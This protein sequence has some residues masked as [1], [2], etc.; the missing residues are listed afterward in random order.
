MSGNANIGGNATITGDLTVNGTTTTI[1]TATLDV[2]DKNITL[3]YGTGD[4]SASADGAGI[5]IQ[6]AVDAS[7]DAT[8]LWNATNDKFVF[9]HDISVTGAS[10]ADNA[11]AFFGTGND[12]SIFHDGSNSYVKD[13]GTGD[14]ML[15]GVNV[16]IQGATTGNNMFVG[17][18]N[19]ASTLYYQNNARLATT[20]AGIDVTGNIIADNNLTIQNSSAYGSIELGGVSG[21]FIDIKRPFSDDYDLRLIAEGD[22]GVINVASGELTIQRAGS[23]KLATSSAGVEVTGTFTASSTITNSSSTNAYL[24][25]QNGGSH[26]SGVIFKEEGSAN[27]WEAPYISNAND[28]LKFYSYTGSGVQMEIRDGVNGNGGTIVSGFKIT[29]GNAYYGHYGAVLL[30]SSQ[31][32]TSTSRGWMITNAYESNKFALLFS[33]SA[34]TLPALT[35]SGATASGTSV[36]LEINN[37]GNATFAGTL[38][39]AGGTTSADL[40]F[41]DNDKAVFGAGSDLQIYHTSSQS[42][43]EDAGTGNLNFKSNGNNFNFLDGS[44]NLVMQID[45]DSETTLYHNTN[46]KLATTSTGIA[47][48]GNATF[49][50]NGKAIFG[51]GSDLSIYHSGSHS[52][53]QDAGTGD[54]QLW[55]N[56]VRIKNAAGTENMAS[57]L[58]NGAAVFNYD[59]SQK[60]ATTSYGVSITG[61]AVASDTFEVGTGANGFLV[62]GGQTGTTTIGKLHN[63]SGVLT[64]DTDSTRSIKLATG[65]TERL[66]I[67]GTTG[68]AGLGTS[69]PAAKLDIVDTSA[70]VQMRVYKNDGTKN[71][72]LTLTA[73]DSGAKIHYRDADNAGALRFNNNLGEVMRIPANTTRL[74]IGTSSPRSTINASSASG[75]ILTLESSDTTLGENEVVGQIDFYANDASTNST[76]NKA[77]I[78][79]YSETAGGNKVALD[80]A[81]STSTSATGVVAMTINSDGDV[82]IGTSSVTSVLDVVGPAA[83]PASLA[84]VDTASTARFRADSTNNDSLYIAEASS[85]MLVQ[86]NDGATNSTTAKPLSLQPFGGNVG[87]GTSP[88]SAL[89]VSDAVTHAASTEVALIQNTTTGQ[90]VALALQAVADNGGTGNE[91]AIYFDAGADGTAANNQLQFTADHQSDTTPDMIITG[92]GNV[93]IGT[94]PAAALDIIGANGDQFRVSNTTSDAT[95]KN[96]YHSVRHYTNAEEDFI[97]SVAQSS[98]SQNTLYLGGSTSLGNAATAIRF[99]TAENTT[100]TSGSERMRIDSSGNLLVGKTTVGINLEGVQAAADGSIA[101]VRDGGTAGYFQ[102]KTSDGEIVN[103]RRDNSTVGSIGANGGDLF[104]GTGDTNIL[105]ADG[106]DTIM[107]ATTGGATRDAAID[108]G[109]SS[110]RFQNLYLSGDVYA[111]NIKGQND[112]NTKIEFLGSDVTRFVQGGSERARLDSGRNLLVGKTTTGVA[113]LGIEARGSGFLGVTRNAA[114]PAYFNRL[115]D[116]GDIAIFS[117]DSS[118]IC[119]IGSI[120]GSMYIQGKAATGKSGLTFYGS[121]IEPRDNGAGA[122]AAI[123]LGISSARF[124]DLYL[125]GTAYIN[126]HIQL[127]NGGELRAKDTGGTVRTIARVNTSNHLEYG[128]SGNGVI[129]FMGKGTYSEVARFDT[130]G[131]YLVGKTRCRHR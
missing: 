78:K 96:A 89:H 127:D 6:D 2:E 63:A 53:I 60:L 67:D 105:F 55:G 35:T 83:R 123:D 10:F 24:T 129:K 110:G 111:T 104:V 130:N 65:S 71:T 51:A 52:I 32:Y 119:T 34:T 31:N 59:N 99:Y 45:I 19:G 18:D 37:S 44:D 46:A 30:N 22:G 1:N 26:E 23:A 81:T 103:F 122:D 3:N 40:N 82:G 57:F 16:R 97:W 56:V 75:A 106:S 113:N 95:L 33:G 42:Y 109:T 118:E 15:Q 76:G 80:F 121:Y 92:A 12:L 14:L 84:E 41:G 91:G 61:N 62:G 102:R 93:G 28:N 72:R 47:V 64:L 94:T 114:A 126:T 49:A 112:V 79:A 120:N 69:S 50:D 8:I 29:D 43:I 36:A 9:S 117:Q 124:R 27:K 108:L 39:F 116:D 17:V 25:L 88:S 4:T 11:K 98:G 58:Q 73:D 107:P 131:H 85:G 70:D 115:T 77:F 90:P 48:T 5:T 68:Y 13:T 38:Q 101:A 100:T 128:W 20:S 21:G 54:L 7:N 86:C 74:G 66:R 125:S 87:I